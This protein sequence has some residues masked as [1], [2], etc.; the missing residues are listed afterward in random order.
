MTEVLRTP[1]GV[2]VIDSAGHS[3]KIENERV[4]RVVEDILRAFL[5]NKEG[6]TFLVADQEKVRRAT[7]RNGRHE[8][9]QQEID[10]PSEWGTAHIG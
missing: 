3:A 9:E 7:R 5:Q 10:V 1:D 4:I 2:L 8:S 6:V